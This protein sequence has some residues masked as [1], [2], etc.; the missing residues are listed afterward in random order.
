MEEIAAQTLELNEI[1]LLMTT[2][3]QFRLFHLRKIKHW[4]ALF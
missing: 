2:G 1:G 4:V 3:D